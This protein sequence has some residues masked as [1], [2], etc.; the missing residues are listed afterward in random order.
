MA[1]ILGNMKTPKQNFGWVKPMKEKLEAYKDR[2]R[3]RGDWEEVKV[4]VMRKALYHKFTEHP[5]LR[6]LLLSTKDCVIMEDSPKDF[7]WGNRKKR[8][9]T[10][11]VG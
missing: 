8:R 4:E 7:Y 11:L 9:R 1:R 3:I 2:V 6:A 10:E 5:Q